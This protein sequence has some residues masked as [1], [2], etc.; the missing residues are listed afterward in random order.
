MNKT[1]SFFFFFILGFSVYYFVDLFYFKSI[2]SFVK[3]LSGSKAV[4]HISAYCITMLPLVI[5]LKILFPEKN[6]TNLFSIN[7]PVLKGLS[8]AFMGTLP[9]LAGY[10]TY[11]KLVQSINFQSLFINSISSPF[12]EEL[13]FRAFLIGIL[14][15]FTRMGFITS[16]LFGSLLFAQVHL[17]Q[18]SSFAELTEIFLITFL[19]SVFFSW[20]YFETDFNL[21]TAISLHL[22][23]NLYWE[24]FNV[25]DNVSGNMYGNLFKVLSILLITALVIYNK[26]R[27]KIPFQI[28]GK[29]LFIKTK[30]M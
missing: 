30:E 7:K 24:I 26:R 9:M 18:G 5:T 15:R 27:N 6:I 2:Q 20:A 29:N 17:Y 14:Y 21:W 8:I 25:S 28:T 11:F 4:A 10:F 16:A 23:M 1:I 13:I 3:Q 12:F 19:G 22:F